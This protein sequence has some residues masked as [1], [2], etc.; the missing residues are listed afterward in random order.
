M[1][2]ISTRNIHTMLMA[3][4]ASVLYLLHIYVH[5]YMH[6]NYDDILH[7]LELFKMLTRRFYICTCTFG[8]YLHVVNIKLP[9]I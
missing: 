6:M 9:L 3:R 8:I 2:T 7:S 5:M 4:T 1:S